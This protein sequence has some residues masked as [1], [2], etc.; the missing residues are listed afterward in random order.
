ML[1]WLQL[2]LYASSLILDMQHRERRILRKD[3]FPT[4]RSMRHFWQSQAVGII[5]AVI[6]LHNIYLHS[7][8]AIESVVALLV[9]FL[10]RTLHRVPLALSC[11]LHLTRSRGGWSRGWLLI[12]PSFHLYNFIF[13]SPFHLRFFLWTLQF[14]IP[15]F[16]PVISI[17]L[18]S[19]F[20][21][22]PFVSG[23]YLFPS[24]SLIIVCCI[25]RR[26]QWCL[27]IPAREQVISASMYPWTWNVG[28]V[29]TPQYQRDQS[30]WDFPYASNGREWADLYC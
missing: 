29:A 26:C 8:L 28:Q 21:L 14:H 10:R 23:W 2:W 6:A 18:S 19:V 20:R 22:R 7:A 12:A 15:F 17:I 16:C 13:L 5:G 11:S 24:V 25:R 9:S 27:C 1:L 4:L 3:L 30:S